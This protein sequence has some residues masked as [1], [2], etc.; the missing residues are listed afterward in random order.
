MSNSPITFDT[1][2]LYILVSNIGAVRQFHWGLYLATTPNDGRV[3]HMVNNIETGYKWRY[4]TR[5]SNNVPISKSLI[6]AVKIAV[7]DPALHGALAGRL[8]VVSEDPPISCLIWL[9]RALKDLDDE[10]FI[11]LFA[12]VEDI[13]MDAEIMAE[14]NLLRQQRTVEKSSH[15]AA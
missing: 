9:R 12:K 3:S 15:S 5:I 6:V 10:G 1:N 11:K 13:V 4:R 2:G 8:K 7:M 14:K